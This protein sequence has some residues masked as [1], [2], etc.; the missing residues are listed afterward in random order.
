MCVNQQ[1]KW[2]WQLLWSRAVGSR[3]I[4]FE[5][6]KHV[7]EERQ[8]VKH[9]RRRVEGGSRG[10][11]VAP[12]LLLY[13]FNYNCHLVPFL[14]GNGM[15][16]GGEQKQVSVSLK[17]ALWHDHLLT[18]KQRCRLIWINTQLT[19]PTTNQ[20]IPQWQSQRQKPVVS[21]LLH[22]NNWSSLPLISNLIQLCC[23]HATYF[24]PEAPG[25]VS[26]CGMSPE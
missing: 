22:V 10:P 6:Q 8:E 24:T 21:F 13:R 3:L 19:H 17:T 11:D 18:K 7:T 16:W 9:C 23:H 1:T 15:T 20:L 14:S 26:L 25:S 4:M 2:K 12:P 5:N